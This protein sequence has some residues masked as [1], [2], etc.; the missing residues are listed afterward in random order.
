MSDPLAVARAGRVE[1]ARRHRDG[2]SDESCASNQTWMPC[3]GWELDLCAVD[4]SLDYVPPP[5]ARPAELPPSVGGLTLECGEEGESYTPVCD[6]FITD[7]LCG[8]QHYHNPY[9]E[10]DALPDF[11]VERQFPAAPQ[12][13]CS[14]AV[15]SDKVAAASK[16]S[17]VTNTTGEGPGPP[18]EQSSSGF[19]R[20]VGSWWARRTD[21]PAERASTMANTPRSR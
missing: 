21:R 19:R 3:M 11:E 6:E 13:S 2:K 9:G 7:Q 15:K 8:T 1:R 4:S 17:D 16:R 12:A 20:L 14:K 10:D 5:P 18:R